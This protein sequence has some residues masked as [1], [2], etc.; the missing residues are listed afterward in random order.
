MKAIYTLLRILEQRLKGSVRMEDIGNFGYAKL[1]G[2]MCMQSFFDYKVLVVSSGANGAWRSGECLQGF[3]IRGFGRNGRSM[4]FAELQNLGWGAPRPWK[5]SENREQHV[6][7]P[8]K[9]VFPTEKG[10]WVP[11]L[12]VAQFRD[13]AVP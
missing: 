13:F 10:I 12:H 8:R 3:L 9:K 4:T 11:F 6:E 1:A 7:N 2:C 5:K